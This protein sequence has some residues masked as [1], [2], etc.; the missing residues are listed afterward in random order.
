MS[1]ERVAEIV[2]REARKH[3]RAD[4]LHLGEVCEVRY[5]A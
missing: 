1:P 2:E 3:Q 4:G 5:E